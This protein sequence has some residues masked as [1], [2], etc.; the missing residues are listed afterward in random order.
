VVLGTHPSRDTLPCVS[1]APFSLEA[2][3]SP[4]QGQKVLFESAN[5]VS[6]AGDD[7]L[8]VP[9]FLDCTEGY[10]DLAGTERICGLPETLHCRGDMA[11]GGVFDSADVLLDIKSSHVVPHFFGQ[12]SL[13][14][15][16]HRLMLGSCWLRLNERKIV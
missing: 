16:P 8:V 12:K 14:N 10:P 4:G 9:G 11:F 2:D 15:K 6:E 3:V 1:G 7:F 5:D 13:S